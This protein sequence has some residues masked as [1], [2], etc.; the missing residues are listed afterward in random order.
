MRKN[1]Y[2]GEK[3]P[4]ESAEKHVSG[5]SQFY[6]RYLELKKLIFLM[7]GKVMELYL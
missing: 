2:I 3:R 1:L 6:D 4:H 5:Q 7:C